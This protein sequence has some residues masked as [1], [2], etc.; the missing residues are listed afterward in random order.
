VT[1]TPLRAGQ[2]VFIYY[3]LR[4]NWQTIVHNGYV[5]GCRVLDE[6][7]PHGMFRPT[8]RVAF[9]VEFT[10]N[11]L[12]LRRMKANFMQVLLGGCP[13]RLSVS[14][15]PPHLPPEFLAYARLAVAS[16][17]QSS[18]YPGDYLALELTGRLAPYSHCVSISYPSFSFQLCSSLFG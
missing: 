8:D 16:H 9:D 5:Q 3:G 10:D 2:Q 13:I 1:K 4:E 14:A 7:I 6:I 17:G 15:S 11:V 18:I 12:E